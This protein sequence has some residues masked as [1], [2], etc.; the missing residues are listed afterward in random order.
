[1][2]VINKTKKIKGV[3]KI[4][5]N[6]PDY[7]EMS[8]WRAMNTEE[9][10][11]GMYCRMMDRRGYN[12]IY[13]LCCARVL[14]KLNSDISYLQSEISRLQQQISRFEI[15]TNR[16]KEQLFIGTERTG[17]KNF[18]RPDIKLTI[19]KDSS[20]IKINGEQY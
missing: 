8:I 14:L 19:E 13:I 4:W 18:S 1:M 17:L 20:V 10:H 2:S 11:Y 3:I 6:E 7:F 5:L 12:D 9:K 15:A 16:I